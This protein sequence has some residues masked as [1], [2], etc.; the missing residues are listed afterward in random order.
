MAAFSRGVTLSK[1]FV[2][3]VVIC[4]YQLSTS[5]TKMKFN[6]ECDKG[7]SKRI[8]RM[9]RDGIETRYPLPVRP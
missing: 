2:M 3:D 6:T 7:H 4:F 8:R 1:L 5:R 9:C